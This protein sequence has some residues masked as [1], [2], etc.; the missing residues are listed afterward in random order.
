MPPTNYSL[1]AHWIHPISSPPLPDHFVNVRDGKITSLTPKPTEH[2]VFDFGDDCR[3]LPGV[4]NAHAHTELSGIGK[5]LDVPAVNG[6]RS[7]AAWITALMQFKRSGAFDPK[8]GIWEAALFPE[9]LSET[10]VLAD[11]VPP[12]AD[13][14]CDRLPKTP[15]RFSF[16]E[17]I[18][19]T[20]DAAAFR[21]NESLSFRDSFRLPERK[22]FGLSPHAP[23]T[24]CPSLLS[25]AVA[26]REPLMMHLAESAEEIEL[27]K[28]RRGPLLDLMRQAD[29]DYDPDAVLLGDR[30]LDYLKR[31][32]DAERAI[33]VH[34]N[35]L[36]DVEIDFLGKRSDRMSVVYCP[37]THAYFGHDSYPLR[38][39]LDAGVCVSLGTDG[40]A[41][42]PDLNLMSEMRFVL[43]V[44]PDVSLDD[45]FRMGTINGAKALGIAPHWGTLEAGKNATFSF[46]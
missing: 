9:I 26:S 43:S 44:H 16:Y 20:P 32:A 42:S 1:G 25:A 24:I 17:L 8:R 14:G 11:V 39:M 5:Q 15:L 40:L 41:S 35:Y 31:L 3:I 10:A 45:V 38:K 28:H 30:P 29:P 4:V 46:W 19:W 13:L 18:A 22:R 34:G 21:M 7:M 2:E 37:R 6:H 27:L 36:E 33:I 23:Q 12:V